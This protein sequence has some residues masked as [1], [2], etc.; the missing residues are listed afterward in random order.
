MSSSSIPGSSLSPLAPLVSISINSNNCTVRSRFLND[1]TQ[2]PIVD[3]SVKIYAKNR[4]GFKHLVG[5]ADTNGNGEI[6]TNFSWSNATNQYTITMEVYKKY[7]PFEKYGCVGHVEKTKI[8]TYTFTSNTQL[9]NF[10]DIR[11]SSQNIS[12]DFTQIKRPLN[13]DMPKAEYFLRLLKASFSSGIKSFIAYVLQKC[14]STERIQK[15]FQSFGPQFKK[16]TLTEKDLLE[17]L[18]NGI[19]AVKYATKNNGDI[20][21]E[22]NWDNFELNPAK[23]RSLPNVTVNANKNPQGDLLLRSIQIK[24]EEEGSPCVINFNSEPF[25][26]FSQKD[27]QTWAIYVAFSVFALKGEIDIHLG[28]G[29]LLAGIIAEQFKKFISPNNPL[30][31]AVINFLVNISFI[32]YLGAQG[33]IFGNGSV[34]ACSALT[35]GSITKALFESIS[36]GADFVTY[37]PQTPITKSNSERAALQNEFYNTFYN[38]FTD[39]IREKA[40]ELDKHKKEIYLFSEAL[41]SYLTGLQAFPEIMAD[42]NQFGDLEKENLARCMARL[43]SLTSYSHWSAHVRQEPLTH[44]D[45][46]SLSMRDYALDKNGKLA[47]Y[48]NTPQSAAITQLRVAYTLLTFKS[49]NMIEGISDDLL[50]RFRN[51]HRIPKEVLDNVFGRVE[52]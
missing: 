34:L 3:Y 7:R 4:F 28:E 6:N 51:N 24:K 5:E 46:A 37:R 2:E 35:S 19:C 33:E 14:I 36:Q 21:W 29:H 42:E 50:Q 30:Y 9:N 48:G 20:V 25:E 31:P 49:F 32:N 38:Y 44:L 27:Q 43:L 52:I 13:Y 17:S 41:R 45:V 40:G 11:L 10:G 39:L 47:A 23:P 12:K 18:L 8:D 16:P 22:A 1:D 26:D 15:I